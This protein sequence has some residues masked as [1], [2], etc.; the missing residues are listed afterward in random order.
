[1]EHGALTMSAS[2]SRS[3]RIPVL[4]LLAFLALLGT[5]A[6]QRDS[7]RGLPYHDS[8]SKGSAAEW[9][10]LGGTWEVVNGAMRNDS[11]ERGAKLL[12]GS[13]GWRDY[14]I[15]AD[16]MLWILTRG[17]TLVCAVSTTHW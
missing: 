8:F 4:L 16:I 7:T 1:M 6:C 14:S 17:T 10:A 12:T 9:K 13:V 2:Q 5:P 3:F 11:D 15:D